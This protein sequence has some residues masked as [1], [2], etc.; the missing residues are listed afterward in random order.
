MYYSPFIPTN[1]NDSWGSESCISHQLIQEIY[2]GA[3]PP[4]LDMADTI[5]LRFF[6]MPIFKVIKNLQVTYGGYLPLLFG[7]IGSE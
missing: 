1:H 2:V 7:R 6:Y 4:V 3:S 5:Y